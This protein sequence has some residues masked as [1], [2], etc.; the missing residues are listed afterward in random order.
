MRIL[1]EFEQDYVAQNMTKIFYTNSFLLEK[2]RSLNN[3]SVF[4]TSNRKAHNFYK[5]NLNEDYVDENSYHKSF[6]TPR[7]QKMQRV[8]H[9]NLEWREFMK[10]TNNGEILL[11]VDNFKY[12]CLN[13]KGVL[14]ENEI[15]QVGVVFQNDL[16]GNSIFSIYFGNKTKEE[17]SECNLTLT[18]MNGRKSNERLT[19][20]RDVINGNSQMVVEISFDAK[21]SWEKT[22]MEFKYK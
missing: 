9:K 3:S 20:V 10:R 15:Y 4:N 8:E 1:K 18:Q 13:K 6:E 14:F 19:G 21:I 16:N 7:A 2:P 12:C 5:E 11:N 17:M 22:I